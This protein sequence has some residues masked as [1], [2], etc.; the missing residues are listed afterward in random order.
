[1]TELVAYLAGAVALLSAG[2]RIRLIWGHRADAG[3]RYLIG[4]GLCVGLSL[5]LLSRSASQAVRPPLTDLLPLLGGE[6][7]LAAG[8]FLALMA[9]SVRPGDRARRWARRQSA[10]SLTVMVAAAAAYLAAGVR[11][12]DG[13]FTVSDSGR[14]ALT[15][16]NALFTAHSLVCVGLFTVVVHRSARHVGPG[17]LRTGLRV[18]VAGGVSAFVWSAL[19][20]FPL[21]VAFRTGHRATAEAS[22]SVPFALL[23]SALGIG[24]ATLP[25]WGA[26]LAGPLRRLRAWRSYRR[27][28]PLWSALHAAHPQIALDARTPGGMLSVPLRNAEFALYRRVIEIHDGRLA[29][30]AHVHPQV[31]DWAAAACA[32][33]PAGHPRAAAVEAA[34]IAAAIEAAAA[35]LRFRVPAV[36]PAPHPDPCDL[37]AEVGWLTEVSDAF[38]RSVA[39]ERIR[40]RVR[41]DLCG[42]P[43]AGDATP[44]E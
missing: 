12:G 43:A 41:T 39:V 23:S 28:G 29:L 44:V 16:Y 26:R 18:V 40:R 6:A 42:N 13:E 20:L 8:S 21:V 38:A 36:S 32:G 35:G 3:A 7:K 27:I 2:H 22:W 31:P 15:V 14:A 30:R 33:L 37:A 34:V 5:V 17:L 10:L 19:G 11:A 9:H 4:L 1:M 25:G 24:G